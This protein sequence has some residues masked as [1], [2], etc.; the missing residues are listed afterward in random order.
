MVDLVGAQR[1]G[2]GER[3]RL[4]E[5][6]RQRRYRQSAANHISKEIS[7]GAIS[8]PTGCCK[9]RDYP[10]DETQSQRRNSLLSGEGGASLIPYG[11]IYTSVNRRRHDTTYH[12]ALALVALLLAAHSASI[13]PFFPAGA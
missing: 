12:T 10:A 8:E 7:G 9:G 11:L 3:Q 6:E 4:G 2:I 13:C 5:S 1:A